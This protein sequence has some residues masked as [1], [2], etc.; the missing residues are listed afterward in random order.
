M[1][2]DKNITIRDLERFIGRSEFEMTH[3]KATNFSPTVL[4]SL[5]HL[6]LGELRKQHSVMI[7]IDVDVTEVRNLLTNH[8]EYFHLMSLALFHDNIHFHDKNDRPIPLE[9]LQYGF[10]K[11]RQI[12]EF[13]YSRDKGRKL[14]PNSPITSGDL[15]N[16]MAHL[17][18]EKENYN[19]GV[20]FGLA[21]FDHLIKEKLNETVYLNPNGVSKTWEDISIWV[22]R[23]FD[24]NDLLINDNLSSTHSIED[25]SI[26]IYELYDNTNEWG[27]TSFDDEMIYSP[28]FR[29]CIVNA[30]LSNQLQDGFSSYE[31]SVNGYLKDLT[32]TDLGTLG[33]PN[34]QSS[35]FETGELG[36]LEISIS[37][38]G[39]GMARRLLGKDYNDIDELEE[40][41]AVINC[42]QK[43]LTSD[44]SGARQVR[45]RGLSKVVQLIGKTGLMRV[46]SGNVSIVRNFLNH[47][48]N[49]TELKEGIEFDEKHY[50]NKLEG[51]CISILYPFK[52]KIK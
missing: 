4:A 39:P 9:K 35:L 28:N 17:K 45:G 26:L 41:E 50:L 29:S 2:I 38:T 20:S 8:Y 51:T 21:C 1:K 32:N 3:V 43:Y 15:Q 27:K 49:S 23:F 30:F 46:R 25:I 52:Y 7:K 11:G 18:R 14:P 5:I 31:E 36:V 6:L 42:F 44:K 47:P 13:A 37:D 16:Y 40:I 12:Q 19:Q 33:L 10:K 48:L 24:F 34:L 22:T